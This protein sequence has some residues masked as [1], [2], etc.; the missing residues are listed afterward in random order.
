M[1]NRVND[2]IHQFTARGQKWL[3]GKPP[4]HRIAQLMFFKQ[5]K[6]LRFD[7]LIRQFGAEAEVK[8]H[9]Q[10]TWN[11]VVTARSRLNIGNLHTG[12]REEFITLIPL[13]SH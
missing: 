1:L 11:N 9:K 10:F 8:L 2:R 3:P 7:H 6:H 12:R 13:N 4:I 5:G